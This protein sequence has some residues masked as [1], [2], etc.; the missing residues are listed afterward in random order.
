MGNGSR[1]RPEQA[2]AD[3]ASSRASSLL[4]PVQ[5]FEAENFA[6]SAID[7]LS[8]H[9]AVIDKD[10]RILLVNKAWRAFATAN[11]AQAASV[12]EGVNYL[13]ACSRA[14][15][16]GD[17]DAQQVGALIAEVAA[18]S[19]NSAHWQYPCHSA[20][21]ER[22]FAMKIT[23]FEEAG[24][25]RIVIA[26]ENITERVRSENQI[27]Y[28]VTHDALTGVP[29]WLLFEDRALQAIE[30]AKQ[31]GLGLAILFIDLNNFKY[32]ND[33][34]GHATGDAVL[35]AF[36]REVEAT[37]PAEDSIARLGGDEFVVSLIDTAI[38]RFAATEAAAALLRRF[39][40]PL[41]VHGREISINLS[42]GVSVYPTDGESLQDLLKHA[43]EAMYCAKAVGRGAYHF[44]SADMSA[45]AAERLLVE[46]ELRRALQRE[47][48][49][50]NYQPQFH[51]P[52]RKIIGMEALIRW[53][54]PELGM[55][56]PDRFIPIA[57][58][59]GLI[60]LI[61]R[62]VLQ[63][64]CAQNQAWQTSGY[65]S[66]PVGVN[67]S[68]LQLMDPDFITLV[69][70]ILSTTGL[71]PHLLEFEITERMYLERST[72]VID[73][74][75]ELRALGIGLSID[76]FG[77]GYSN[78]ASLKSFPFDRLKIDRSFVE[79]IPENEDA[80]AIIRTVI[81]LGDNL[82]LRVIAEGVETAAQAAYLEGVGCREAQGFFYCVPQTAAEM[83]SRLRDRPAFSD[84]YRQTR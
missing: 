36:A 52:S 62:K 28:L 61:G 19:R 9:I 22:W 31:T 15:M 68:A 48:F 70:E 83:E 65:L 42:I 10:G 6:R 1:E 64:A 71:D 76:D 47:Q 44:Y 60:G 81:A 20:S 37:L 34:Y 4:G 67:I 30:R 72:P 78:L 25:V 38:A 79:G 23:R 53:P 26:H 73:Q 35:T 84:P 56:P 2:R 66:V 57:E 39:E 69:K 41:A 33:V 59:T 7:A 11:G 54:H 49:E 21:E 17:E 12:S 45:R 27:A 55:I 40:L 14:A 5:S 74:L 50:L 8:T 24:A 58:A 51:I 29:N 63:T 75:Q 46:S 16:S 13:E 82:G 43:D 77:T 18:G 3:D 32:L 80:A